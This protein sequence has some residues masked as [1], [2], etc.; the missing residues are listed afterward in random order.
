MKE[1]DFTLYADKTGSRTF[2]FT[3]QDNSIYDLTG[4]IVDMLL[5]LDPS[6][7]VTIS[8]TINIITGKVTF[9][10]NTS[11]TD[12]T[13]IYE[14]IIEE[15]K[16]NTSKVLLTRGNIIIKEY[17]PFSLSV[18]AFLATELPIDITLNDNF[19]T[20]KII[21]WR[22]FLMSAFNIS[23]IYNDSVW[24]PMQNAL[25]A[26]LVAYEVLT[27]AAKGSLLSVLGGTYNTTTSSSEG[28]VKRIV[29]GPAEV[30]F[31][32]AGDTIQQIF[33]Q[34]T[35][36]NSVLDSLVKDICGLAS[37]L[38]VKVPMCKYVNVII[39]PKY[40]QNAN[41]HMPTAEEIENTVISQGSIE[42]E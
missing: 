38:K 39:G 7:P 2:G 40:Y 19:V 28:G 32:P 20:Q 42:Q 22:T 26:K 17:V 18:E 33:K 13:G 35:A 16:L 24:S 1:I 29:T 34:D 10:F 9:T 27:L 5:Y 4:S 8:G 41:W 36:G 12:N 14:Y 37:F 31:F 30:E 21:Y 3:N 11:N 15:T 6:S 23:T 25:I